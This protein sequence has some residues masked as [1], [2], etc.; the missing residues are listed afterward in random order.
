MPQGTERKMGE[1][2]H[3]TGPSPYEPSTNPS[4]YEIQYNQLLEHN[5]YLMMLLDK[6]HVDIQLRMYLLGL[7]PNGE[8]PPTNDQVQMWIEQARSG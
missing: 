4:K 5:K 2:S 7:T 1:S 8:H 6:L 3:P